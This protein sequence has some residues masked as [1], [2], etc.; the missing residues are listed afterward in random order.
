MTRTDKVLLLATL[1]FLL[2]GILTAIDLMLAIG[3]E[4][5][6]VSTAS[7]CYPWGAEGPAGEHWQYASKS[8]YLISGIASAVL[9]IAAATTAFLGT[10]ND[11]AL[12]I[13]ARILVVALLAATLGLLLT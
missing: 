2:F 9:P 3:A 5:C 10:R 1:P 12:S 11:R 13:S 4:P 8:T 7:G 6:S